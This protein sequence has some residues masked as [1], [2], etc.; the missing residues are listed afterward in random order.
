MIYSHPNEPMDNHLFNHK[1]E[2][3][4]AL[5]LAIT[6]NDFENGIPILQAGANPN[7]LFLIEKGVYACSVNLLI[8]KA[9]QIGKSKGPANALY[10]SCFKLLKA[11]VKDAPKPATLECKCLKE[12]KCPL[13]IAL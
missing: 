5:F 1:N 9:A 13:Y 6:R 3:D 4:Q 8:S 11:M 2:V 12:H 10:I 7:A